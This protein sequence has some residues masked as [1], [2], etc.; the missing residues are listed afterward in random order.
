MCRG[1]AEF[2]DPRCDFFVGFV[3][4]S[5]VRGRGSPALVWVPLLSSWVDTLY[6][7]YFGIILPTIK[8]K[9]Y[10]FGGAYELSS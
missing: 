3:K 6:T 5:G 10:T 7:F 9:V 4:K 8:L 2:V 1:C